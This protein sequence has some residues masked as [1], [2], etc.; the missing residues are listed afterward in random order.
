MALHQPASSR[1]CQ[2]HC[3]DCRLLPSTGSPAL[4]AGDSGVP[5]IIYRPRWPITGVNSFMG[6]DQEK[7]ATVV[8]VT[9]LYSVP[10]G[11][12][13]AKEITRSEEH[14]SELQSRQYLVC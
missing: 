9:K 2:R 8:V 5:W 7:G 11:S 13:P 12:Q 3:R 14:T 1:A 6:Y 10:D 4:R